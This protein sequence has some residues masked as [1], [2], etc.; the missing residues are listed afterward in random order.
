MVKVGVILSGCGV[1]DGSEINEAV[2][3]LLALDRAGAEVVCMAPDVTQHHV[4]DHR[5][6]EPTGETRNVLTESAR[7]AR[8]EI[9]DVADVSASELDAVMLPGGFGAAKNLCSF[10]NDGSAAKVEPTV[11][12]LLAD[13]VAARKPLAAVCIAPAVLATVLRD[14]G[15]Q[16][17]L[18]IGTDEGTAKA[19]EDMGAKHV[20]CPVDE[21]RVDEEHRIIT[22]PAYMLAGRISEAAAGIE[23]TVQ[24]LVRMA[25]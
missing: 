8:G 11:G 7:I 12:R 17:E 18:T 3:T 2:L 21:C 22:S 9:K 19:L 20:A 5:T 6:G 4:I 24:E 15:V 25:G 14:A 13:M 23:R 10:A 1:Q 16:G